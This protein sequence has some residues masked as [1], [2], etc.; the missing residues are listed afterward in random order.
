MREGGKVTRH[1]DKGGRGNKCP[2][3]GIKS[4][5]RKMASQK[6]AVTKKINTINQFDDFFLSR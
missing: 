2:H 1:T 4:G 5:K 3:M 6:V